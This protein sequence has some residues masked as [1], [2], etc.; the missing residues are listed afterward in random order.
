MGILSKA[1]LGLG[2]GAILALSVVPA[3]AAIYDRSGKS[4]LEQS[5]DYRGWGRYRHRD[6]IDGGDILAG[7]GVLAGIAILAD[8][9]SKTGRADRDYDRYPSDYDEPSNRNYDHRDSSRNDDDVADAVQACSAAAERQSGDYGD[10]VDEIHSVRRDGQ[11][12]RVEGGLS[13]DDRFTCGAT[14]GNVDF[15]QIDGND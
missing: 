12:W 14:N 13:N 5:Q 11:S 4:T 1:A 2:G 3:S 7:I 8:A 6:R 15:I 9:V 10:R